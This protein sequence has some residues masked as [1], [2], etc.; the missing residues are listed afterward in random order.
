[1]LSTLNSFLVKKALYTDDQCTSKFYSIYILRQKCDLT[2]R[3]I[4]NLID[5]KYYYLYDFYYTSHLIFKAITM[6]FKTKL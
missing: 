4:I 2:I 6:N 5:Y 3:V 1:M